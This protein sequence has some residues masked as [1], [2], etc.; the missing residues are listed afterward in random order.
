M[1]KATCQICNGSRVTFHPGQSASEPC[2]KC[3]S[4]GNHVDAVVAYMR[5]TNADRNE[6]LK[7]TC[8]LFPELGAW[9]VGRVA[10]V[11]WERLK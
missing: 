2:W 9:K 7:I 6:A 10:G 11:A 5:A 8:D 1:T 3:E 4:L